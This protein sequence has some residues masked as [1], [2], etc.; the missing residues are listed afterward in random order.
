LNIVHLSDIHFEHCSNISEAI[1][2]QTLALEIAT[3][4]VD[5]AVALI[6]GCARI[7]VQI[8][9]RPF[10]APVERLAN[11]CDVGGVLASRRLSRAATSDG[12]KQPGRK[13]QSEPRRAQRRRCHWLLGSLGDLT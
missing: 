1:K 3:T 10:M 6:G 11:A 8:L 12:R 9:T 4:F 7:I 13:G 2:M 5:D